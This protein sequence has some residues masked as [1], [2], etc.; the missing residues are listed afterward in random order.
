[1]HTPN[2]HA[3]LTS[4]PQSVTLP[5][6][7]PRVTIE[8]LSNEVLL[9]IF[10][11]YLHA[12]PRFWL[13][14]V[15]IC[16][17]WRRI[18][19]ASQ[20]ALHL[21]LFSTYGTPVLKTLECWPALPIVMQ[22]GGS[23][24]LDPPAPEDED[25]IM[26]ALKQS[27]RVSSI[28]LTMTSSLLEKLSGIERP[29]SQ[30]EE[31]VLLS[32]DSVWQTLPRAFRWGPRL[33]CL[34]STRVAFPALLHLLYSSKN[35]VDLQLHEV[36]NPLHL[37]PDA[38]TDALS[39]TPQLRSLSL[40][41]LTTVNYVSLDLLPPPPPEERIVFPALTRL[42]FRGIAEYLEGL[43][44]RIDAPRLGDIE[45][46]LFDRFVFDPSKLGEFIDRIEIQKSPLQADIV[47]SKRAISISITQPEAPTRLK[48]QVSCKP[49]T[50]QVSYMA[51][52]CN[53][54]STFLLGVEHLCISATRPPRRQDRSGLDEH[55]WAELI[56][57][58]RG[59]KW[60]YVAGDHW[61]NIVRALQPSRVLPALHRLNI[62]QPRPR[63]APLRE[64][65]VSFMTS[66]WL[67]GHSVAVE[68][69][70]QRHISELR[71]TGPFSQ[72]A[73]IE[74]LSDDV[75]LRI[76]QHYLDVSP[77]NWPKLAH[78]SRSWRQ[79]IFTSPLGLHLRLYCTYGTPVLKNLDCWPSLPLVLDYVGSPILR[80]PAPED[81][82]NI[83]AVLEQSDRIRSISLTV[84]NS[85]LKKLSA[86]SEPISG[87]EELVLLSQDNVQSTLPRANTFWWGH[88]LRILHSTRIAIP[89]LPQLLLPSQDLVDLQL[90]DIPRAG[91]FSP[92][93]FANALC[94]MTR[95]ET[96][97]LHF[98]S[99]PP[100]R[101]YLA[102]PPP[103]W[104]RVVLPA[105]TRFKYRGISKYLDNLVAR[106]D[107]PRLGDIDI[108][109][110]N[111]P[112]LDASQLGLFV[113]RI[114]MWRS[115][116]RAEILFSGDV[117]SITFTQPGVLKRLGLQISCEQLGW[118]L[119]SIYQICGH[120]STFL[121]N[122]EYLGIEA[123]GPSRVPDDIDDEQWLGPI[124]AFDSIK[125]FHLAGD[126]ATDILRALR[127]AEEGD[128]IVLPSLRSLHVQE[129]RFLH[130][131][132]RDSVQ[133]FVTQRRHSGRPILVNFSL[134]ESIRSTPIRRPTKEEVVSA[135]R[136]V[137]EERRT[138][139]NHSFGVA[140]SPVPESEI[141]EYIRNLE[142][143]DMVLA[144]IERYIHIAFAALR[145]EDVVRRMFNMMASTKCQLEECK[146]PNPRYV[147]ELHTIRGMIREADNMDKGLRTVLGLKLAARA[148]SPVP[149]QP[150]QPPP[151]GPT[152]SFPRPAIGT[153]G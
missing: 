26:A 20:W 132:L 25:N 50:R 115:P 66:R 41:L 101:N 127:S 84:S 148:N 72:Q 83:M 91:Y 2:R 18:V 134:A 13:R 100:R 150:Q 81:E 32:R 82:D 17:K 16:R 118:R 45:V 71:G 108:T 120:F 44:A 1:M 23:L 126:L 46:T 80:P 15:H 144:N 147:L 99:L 79:I 96:L 146:K 54:L 125:S 38:F 86:I 9:E 143:L 135:K 77:R 128:K 53:G 116:L 152:P 153:Q 73:L 39:G 137:E 30:L 43:V 102:F 94:G 49:L 142:R 4:P 138:A 119:S 64:A 59:A 106:I 5:S 56:F 70:Q 35:L 87:L 112:T 133:S 19:F 42:N 122:V 105:L 130:G 98:L 111:Q 29:F 95:L 74:V 48:L 131:P 103:P 88:R 145:K 31:I 27:D 36:I 12:D 117:I 67:G 136:W 113:N 69:E 104:N 55:E 40:H 68:Y 22:Y 92:E 151:M 76:F 63:H 61:T 3:R 93:A 140:S 90:N 121:F 110:F 7:C 107:A 60:V 139:F 124:R 51:Q 47:S 6:E 149:Q 75:L 14:L 8:K 21:R 57:P 65:V 78:V 97:S 10:R 34:H 33:R 129:P 52:I 24:A 11:Y 123:N 28:R 89:S 141:P 37:S 58:F 114:E 62:A 85:L 109:F